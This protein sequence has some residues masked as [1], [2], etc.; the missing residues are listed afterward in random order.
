MSFQPNGCDF[1]YY[2]FQKPLDREK[3]DLDKEDWL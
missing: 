2:I 1:E 3:K